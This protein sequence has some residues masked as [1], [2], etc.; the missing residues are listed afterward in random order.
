MLASRLLR[1]RVRERSKRCAHARVAWALRDGS[2]DQLPGG[3]DALA[4]SV[5]DP[6]IELAAASTVKPGLSPRKACGRFGVSRDDLLVNCPEGVT[7]GTVLF[8]CSAELVVELDRRLD[9]DGS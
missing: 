6:A 2:L 1:S 8:V 5:V 4:V 9:V 7:I 3:I